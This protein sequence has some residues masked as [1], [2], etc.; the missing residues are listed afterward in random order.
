VNGD[1]ILIGTPLGHANPLFMVSVRNIHRVDP[2]VA[3]AMI[4]VQ[5]PETLQPAANDEETPQ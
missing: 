3:T 2:H 1:T 5:N 4:D